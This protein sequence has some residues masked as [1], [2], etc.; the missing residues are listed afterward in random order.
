MNKT[1][2]K[3]KKSKKTKKKNN[4]FNSNR[5][6]I[7]IV[8]ILITLSVSLICNIFQLQ[9]KCVNTTETIYKI[10]ENIVFFGDSITNQY[11]INEFFPE[12]NIVNSGIS[13][14]EASDLVER[15]EKDVYRY[16]P[17]KVFLLIGINDLN[18]KV[19]DKEILEN[20]QKIVN[21]IKTNRKYAKIYIQSVY[22]VNHEAFQ[23]HNYSFNK[24][25]DAKKIKDFNKKLKELCNEN[26]ITYIDVFNEL[27]DKDGNL[28]KIYTVEGL[29]IND[30][31]YFKVTS[32]LQKYIYDKK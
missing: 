19:S 6:N 15:I 14:D 7:L 11:K 31:G 26:N 21:G 25:V 29:H 28:K 32:V 24:D 5:K 16:N 8:L 17:S 4:F 1:N 12:V 18:H 10:D 2:K 9:N 13:G 20:I 3:V 23:E 22:P 30:L 27:D